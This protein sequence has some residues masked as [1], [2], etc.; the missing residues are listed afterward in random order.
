MKIELDKAERE[1]IRDALLAHRDVL[2][3]RGLLALD[4]DSETSRRDADRFGKIIRAGLAIDDKLS[5]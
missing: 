4:E 5:F 1:L 2:K 3:H